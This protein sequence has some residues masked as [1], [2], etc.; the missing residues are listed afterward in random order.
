MNNDIQHLINF[1]QSLHQNPELSG[2]E[3]FTAEALKRMII[4]YQPDDIIDN[5]GGYGVAFVFKS[6][7][8]GPTI[9][10]R[11]DMDALPIH[12]NSNIDYVSRTEG[13]S[14]QCGHDGHM[15]ILVGLA[16][17]ISIN[18]PKKGKVVLL[19][20]P[21]EE[22]GEGALAVIND[23]NFYRIEP[24]YC[25]ALHNIPGYEKG[26]VVID[27]GTFA[28]ASEGISIKLTG[29]TSHAA[30]PEKGNSPALAMAEII[31]RITDIPKKNDFT[32]YVLTTVVHARLGEPTYGTSPGL[33]EILATLRAYNNNDLQL[34]EA[35]TRNIVDEICRINNLE[36]DI[37]LT[38]IFPSVQNDA[39]LTALIIEKAKE[40]DLQIVKP[41]SVF[42]WSEDFSQFSQHYKSVFF[43]I[44]AGLETPKLHNANYN[45]PDEILPVGIGLFYNVYR[46]YLAP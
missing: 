12:E 9:L 40:L 16:E 10:F 24:D 17:Q 44:G 34:L 21:A 39:A 33:A 19:F 22:T 28:A 45:F 32:D 43:G 5:L 3:E 46:H 18:R 13:V 41:K 8:E 38:D 7:K 27:K 1:R 35:T 30:E 2:N 31:Q 4:K 26:K 14:H 42:P 25:F 11:A 6:R 29:K 20:Q 36:G 23:Q 15:A 37:G